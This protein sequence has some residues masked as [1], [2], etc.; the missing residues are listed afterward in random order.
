MT[1][2]SPVIIDLITEDYITREYKMKRDM[3]EMYYTL[4]IYN[5]LTHDAA[6]S[7]A[8]EMIKHYS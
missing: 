8:T 7:Y 1:C 6:I 4:G 3:F 5:G 2:T